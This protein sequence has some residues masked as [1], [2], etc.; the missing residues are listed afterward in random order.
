MLQNRV[1]EELEGIFQGSDRDP[2]MEDLRCMHLMERCIKEAL[3][4]YP[5]VPVIARTLTED[6]PMGKLANNNNKKIIFKKILKSF[7]V[8]VFLHYN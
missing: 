8:I 7:N 1:V 5:S 6:Q 4:L 2:N 3:R